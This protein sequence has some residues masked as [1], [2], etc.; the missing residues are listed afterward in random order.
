ML[1][2]SPVESPQMREYGFTL[3]PGKET[4]VIITPHITDADDSIQ[5]IAPKIRQCYFLNEKRLRYYRT[6]TQRNC[7]L[8]CEA[9]FTLLECHCM[10]YYMPGKKNLLFLLISL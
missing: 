1:L 10:R 3:S 8:E 2:H 7:K 6:Y 4:R 9:N 5:K